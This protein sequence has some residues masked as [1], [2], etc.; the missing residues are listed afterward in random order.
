MLS[1]PE[2]IVVNI[3]YMI[4][5]TAIYKQSFFLIIKRLRHLVID[6]FYSFI[7]R[8]TTIATLSIFLGQRFSLSLFFNNTSS[9]ILSEG[10]PGYVQGIES[11]SFL[12]C[13]NSKKKFSLRGHFSKKLYFVEQ[14]SAWIF[15]N[16]TN[17]T[18]SK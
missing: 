12:P 3:S 4:L 16:T 11:S 15:L 13:S 8:E 9:D 14:A 7:R 2:E 17:F 1:R 5:H 6:D 18:F 10:K